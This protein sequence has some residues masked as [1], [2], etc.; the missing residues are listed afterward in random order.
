[1]ALI[2]CDE[3]GQQVSDRS[4]FCPHCGFPTHL[5]KA[6]RGEEPET[7]KKLE[8]LL[9]EKEEQQ[10]IS[11]ISPI[12]PID[13]DDARIRRNERAKLIVFIG[14]F[15]VLLAAILFFY[16]TA[17]DPSVGEEEMTEEVVA[18]SLAEEPDTA[19]ADTMTAPTPAAPVVKSKVRP[20]VKPEII[21]PASPKAK[22][23]NT[24]EKTAEPQVKSLREQAAPAHTPAPAPEAPAE[25]P[26]PSPAG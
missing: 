10:P 15:A 4:L 2:K 17:P 26:V 12:S 9:S 21:K 7:F 16:F 20:A 8:S 22:T 5:N 18:D 24:A 3:C 23:V 1:M 13:D 25:T 6:F 14:V 11:P 19:A